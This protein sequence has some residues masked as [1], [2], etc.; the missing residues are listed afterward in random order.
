MPFVLVD[1]VLAVLERVCYI[2]YAA[3]KRTNVMIRLDGQS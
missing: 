1:G 2:V 3:H